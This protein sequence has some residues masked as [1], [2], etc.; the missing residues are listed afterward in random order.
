MQV[1]LEIS[2]LLVAWRMGDA[3]ALNRLFPLVYEELKR[4]ARRQRA[5][6]RGGGTLTTTALVHETYLRLVDQTRAEWADRAHFL[7]IAARAMRQLLIDHAR[8]HQA[9]KRGG[10][11]R[12]VTLDVDQSPASSVADARAETL[13]TLDAA[14]TRLAGIDER[15]SRVVECR[16][17]GGMTEAETA[18]ALG[19]TDRTVQRDWVKAKGWLHQALGE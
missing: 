5:G 1:E 11:W 13:L 7:A 15:A 6:K 10:A 9:A 19:V 14:L 3:D 17:F 8:R 12:R 18:A 4:I 16:F 2:E